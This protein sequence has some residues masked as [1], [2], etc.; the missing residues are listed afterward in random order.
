MRELASPQPNTQRLNELV[1]VLLDS[2]EPFNE[3][4]IGG[5]PWQVSNSADQ[6]EMGQGLAG[7]AGTGRVLQ[8]S[9]RVLQQPGLGFPTKRFFP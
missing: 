2:S 5:G 8:E 3:A 4:I 1:D 9:R 7:S 6:V